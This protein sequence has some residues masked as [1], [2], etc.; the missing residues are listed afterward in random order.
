VF[1]I[2]YDVYDYERVGFVTQGPEAERLGWRFDTRRRG[3]GNSGHEYG[4][5]LSDVQ[6]AA[7][8]EYLKTF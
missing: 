4:T 6:K 7:L 1:Y 8:I 5:K 2:G 3:N